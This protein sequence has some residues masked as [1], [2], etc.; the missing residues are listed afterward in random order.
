MEIENIIFVVTVLVLGFIVY[1]VFIRDSSDSGPVPTP[2]PS[3]PDVTPTPSPTGDLNIRVD[4]ENNIFLSKC[5]TG[6]AESISVPELKCSF[7]VEGGSGDYSIREDQCDSK[8]ISICEE[9]DVEITPDGAVIKYPGTVFLG[10]PRASG[11]H[12]ATLTFIIVDNDSG[13]TR[14]QNLSLYWEILS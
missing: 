3:I 12:D 7:T 10:C 13:E 4:N 9:T 14:T 1:R 11:L 2:L 6:M 8:G 5:S